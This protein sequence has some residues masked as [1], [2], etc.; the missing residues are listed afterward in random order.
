MHGDRDAFAALVSRATNQAYAL[1]CL[2][3][4]D[5]DRAQDATQDAFVR[6]WR[7]LPSLRDADRFDAWLRRLVVNACY[8]EAR[9]V[10]RRA[11]VS[12]A[13]MPERSIVD[14]ASATAETD[15]VER[16]FRRLPLDQRTVLVLQ[17]YLDLSHDEIAETRHPARDRQVTTPAA[18]GAARG[19]DG[20]PRPR[21]RGSMSDPMDRDVDR[22]TDGSPRSPERAPTSILEGTF[23]TIMTTSQARPMPWRR[24]RIGTPPNAAFS[25]LAW[26]AL[27]VILA[28]A[29]VAVALLSSGG[30]PQ[31]TQVLP[32]A[33]ATASPSPLAS[34]VGPR[35]ISV[36]PE[37]TIAVE[38]P[39]FMA[40]DGSV[41]WLIDAAGEVVRIDPG[42]NA[43]GASRPIGPAGDP[44]QGIAADAS[45]VWVTDWITGKIFRVDPA[46]LRWRRR[47]RPGLA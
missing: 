24:I 25:S 43:I 9:R 31:M 3:L 38:S 16:A 23:A 29:L 15:R 37:A 12:L 30:P 27:V 47:S 19:L 21:P 17:H 44:Y 32:S 26:V 39:L 7:D 8:D 6:A 41:P 35:P 14:S 1:A 4:R 20:R 36:K 46:T 5:S 10:H 13:F 33:S 34:P 11:E 22:S 45:G 28:I 40:T 42:A 18:A 2:M